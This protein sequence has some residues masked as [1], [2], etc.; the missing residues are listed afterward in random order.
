MI[1]YFKEIIQKKTELTKSL[2]QKINEQQ[3]TLKELDLK[4]DNFQ[5]VLLIKENKI[6]ELKEKEKLLCSKNSP[7]LQK[8]ELLR[9]YNLCF[10]HLMG[11]NCLKQEI[12]DNSLLYNFSILSSFHLEI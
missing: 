1:L 11:I 4:I 10:Q 8:I 9:K 3:N 2:S 12:N 7:L 5:Q 6:R